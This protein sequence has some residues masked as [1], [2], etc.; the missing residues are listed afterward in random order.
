MCLSCTTTYACA[1]YRFAWTPNF[2]EIVGENL[3][4]FSSDRLLEYFGSFLFAAI[5]D[6]SLNDRVIFHRGII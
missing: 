1:R 2:V 3:H 4:L 6:H 5:T